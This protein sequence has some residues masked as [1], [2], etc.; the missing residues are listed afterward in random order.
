MSESPRSHSEESKAKTGFALRKIWE[1]RL[2]RKSLQ[3][4]CYLT[5]AGIVAEAA[6]EGGRDRQELEWDSFEKMKSDILVQHLQWK[7]DRARQKEIAKRRAERAAKA[8]AGKLVRHVLDTNE[9]QKVKAVKSK[10]TLKQPEKKS[11]PTTSRDLKLRA[12]LAKINR[13][14]QFEGHLHESEVMVEVQATAGKWDLEF[15]KRDKMHQTVSFAD[16]ILAIK[17]RRMVHAA[18]NVLIPSSSGSLS[19]ENKFI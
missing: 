13:K 2:K 9:G 19:E 14:Q 6:R 4:K 16:Q 7:T 1:E 10:G 5:W 3:E 15:I 18:K 11:V 17:K 8:K 12:R